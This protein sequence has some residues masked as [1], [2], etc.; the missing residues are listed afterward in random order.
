[1]N[2]LG[3]IMIQYITHVPIYYISYVMLVLQVVNTLH[4]FSLKKLY[5][6]TIKERKLLRMVSLTFLLPHIQKC[7]LITALQHNNNNISLHEFKFCRSIDQVTYGSSW[8]NN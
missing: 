4:S 1:M 7:L 2:V 8:D 5:L 6:A 3:S